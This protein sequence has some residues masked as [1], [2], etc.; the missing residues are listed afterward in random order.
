MT[1]TMHIKKYFLS[2]LILVLG[3]YLLLVLAYCLPTEKI[4]ENVAEAALAFYN[5]G[6]YHQLNFGGVDT[7]WK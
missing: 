2:F 1:L 5:E 6:P 4:S 7:R 3:G